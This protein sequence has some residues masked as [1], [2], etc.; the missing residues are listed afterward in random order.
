MRKI[1]IV[2]AWP[3]GGHLCES[4]GCRGTDAGAG[5]ETGQGLDAAEDGMGR[6]RS[7]RRLHQ[8]RREPDSVRAAGRARRQ[9]AG[10]YHAR[11]ARQ[12]GRAARCPA[13]GGRP[14]SRRAAKPDPL[15]REH[16]SEQ[17]PRLACSD[18]PDGKVPAPTAEA[19][20]RNAARARERAARGP[21]DSAEDRSL[22]DRCISRGIPGSMMPAIYGNAYEI[23]Q[24]P[25][26]VVITYEMVHEARVIPLTPA[27]HVGESI[28]MYMGDAQRPLGGQYARRRDDELHGQDRLSRLERAP[29]AD[30]ALHAHRTGDGRMVVHLQRSAHVGDA[31]DLRDEP[32]E[33]GRQPAPVR[34]RLPRRELRD[35]PPAAGRPRRRQGRRGGCE[36]RH[37]PHAHAG[38]ADEQE[39]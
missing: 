21:A 2:L 17:Q 4:A 37:R 5:E 11:R 28:H 34:V 27:P 24:G 1:T 38:G 12:A 39:R 31:V 7:E 15:V 3:L 10:G 26:Y 25:G 36:E 23:V 13:R 16:F 20:Q 18:P 33:E 32:H 22:Y 14:Q 8:Q 19:Q 9:D 6:S 30:G 35:V 29:Q